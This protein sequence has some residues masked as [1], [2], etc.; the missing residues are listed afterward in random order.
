MP[1]S[2]VTRYRVRSA[3][4]SLREKLV[5]P[6]VGKRVTVTAQWGQRAAY[7]GTSTRETFTGQVIALAGVYAGAGSVLVLATW[8]DEGDH[9][10]VVRAFPLSKI[11]CIDEEQ[12]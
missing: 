3:N 10:A 12:S 7:D 5:A 6:C 11:I 1:K 4:A 2:Q 8:A 9:A